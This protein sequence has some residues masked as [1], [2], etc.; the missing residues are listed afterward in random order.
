M[1]AYRTSPGMASRDAQACPE[2]VPGEGGM[3]PKSRHDAETAM[4]VIGLGRPFR[5]LVSWL[6]LR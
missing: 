2:L 4:H 6:G 1:A 3:K 5:G